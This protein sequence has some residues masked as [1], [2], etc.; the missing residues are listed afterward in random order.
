MAVSAETRQVIH[1]AVNAAMVQSDQRMEMLAERAA[2]K[3]FDKYRTHCPI[4]QVT[5]DLWGKSGDLD[6][7]IKGAVSRHESSLRAT[8]ARLA[9]MARAESEKAKSLKGYLLDISK[10]LVVGLI[11][12][13]T[14]AAVTYWSLRR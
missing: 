11:V 12:A 1:E 9:N 5:K 4:G 3:T 13:V 10:P 8:N 7:G 14:S 2:E 6:G